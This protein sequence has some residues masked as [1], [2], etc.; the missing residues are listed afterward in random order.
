MGPSGGTQRPKLGIA[1]FSELQD[2]GKVLKNMKA[3]NLESFVEDEHKKTLKVHPGHACA[4]QPTA[5]MAAEL[6]YDCELLKRLRSIGTQTQFNSTDKSLVPIA[7][8]RTAQK[9]GLVRDLPKDL[10]KSVRKIFDDNND[11]VMVE[12][13]LLKKLQKIQRRSKALEN[14]LNF[15]KITIIEDIPYEECVE[16]IARISKRVEEIKIIMSKKKKKK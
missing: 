13:S 12:A 3:G 2:K 14:Q 4:P 15:N 16:N 8:N 9:R 1:F 5:E 6:E 7:N 10:T 11:M